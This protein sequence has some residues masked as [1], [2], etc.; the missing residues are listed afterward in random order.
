[1]ARA[2]PLL[3]LL[4]LPEIGM[5]YHFFPK[6][7]VFL[8]WRFP[9]FQSNGSIL[10]HVTPRMWN[11]WCWGTIDV[12]FTVLQSVV[13]SSL[14]R[15]VLWVSPSKAI[16]TLDCGMPSANNSWSAS[17]S[18]VNTHLRTRC[19]ESKKSSTW[20]HVEDTQVVWKALRLLDP[21][22]AGFTITNMKLSAAVSALL[23]ASS[24]AFSPAGQ[25]ARVSES[26]VMQSLPKMCWNC[27]PVRQ[28]N[29][30]PK[31]LWTDNVKSPSHDFRG[32]GGFKIPAWRCFFVWV[33]WNV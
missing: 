23:I 11:G 24:S 32:I 29:L 18:L 12:T 20:G 21:F 14:S 31:N 25:S 30:N 19:P 4:I 8:W 17:F 27:I 9:F 2:D 22:L 7:G 6:G 26:E 28:W 33:D 10:R 5:H 3:G 15:L 13:E 1:M 16:S